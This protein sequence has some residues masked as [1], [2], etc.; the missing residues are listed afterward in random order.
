MVEA[1]YGVNCELFTTGLARFHYID[2]R[3]SSRASG[4]R[5]FPEEVTEKQVGKCHL[6]KYFHDCRVAMP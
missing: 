6:S 4:R 2:D 5:R 3:F 1:V